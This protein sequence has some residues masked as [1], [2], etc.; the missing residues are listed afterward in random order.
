ML[1][2]VYVANGC[3]LKSYTNECPAAVVLCNLLFKCKETY[4][5]DKFD[6]QH[7]FSPA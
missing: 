1:E 5:G 6:D 3:L 4:V 7:V 2:P